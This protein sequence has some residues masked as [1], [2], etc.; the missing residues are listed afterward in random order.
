[1]VGTEVCMTTKGIEVRLCWIAPPPPPRLLTAT[2]AANMLSLQTHKAIVSV[3]YYGC[4]TVLLKHLCIQP[5]Y[6]VS[7]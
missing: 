2:P 6:V 5:Y 4:T 1:M 7:Q 3:L